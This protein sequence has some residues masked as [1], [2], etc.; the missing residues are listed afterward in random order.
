MEVKSTTSIVLQEFVKQRFGD[1][2]FKKWLEALSPEAREVY[3]KK[4]LTNLW[5]PL[6]AIYTDPT[7]QLC[8]LFYKGDSRGAYECGVYGADYALKG[9]YSF[10]VKVGSPETIL[11]K[12]SSIFQTYFKPSEIKSEILSRNSA[13][14]T[15]SNFPEMHVAIEYRIMGYIHKTLEIHGCKNVKDRII[16]SI[17]FRQPVSELHFDWD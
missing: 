6:T 4:I 14:L 8:N 5:Q 12:A 11:K 16:K 9:I 1:D 17:L 10:F 3:S 13:R 7:V 15:I 2:G